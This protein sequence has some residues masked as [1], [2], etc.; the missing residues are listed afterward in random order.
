M[1]NITFYIAYVFAGIVFISLFMFTINIDKNQ[2]SS[3]KLLVQPAEA[4]YYPIDDCTD[5]GH[6][7]W[8]HPASFK[9]GY[10]CLCK[11]RQ[12]VKNDC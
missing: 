5:F 7:S 6:Q 2:D 10:D 8:N 3:S 4:S 9:D 1:K 11:A 12:K